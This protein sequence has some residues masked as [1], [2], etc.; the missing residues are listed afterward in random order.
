MVL[1]ALRTLS[2]FKKE[3][4]LTINSSSRFNVAIYF[5]L[6]HYFIRFIFSELFVYICE[7]GN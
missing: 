6:S 4:C 5:S 7:E 3:C 2:N 1:D